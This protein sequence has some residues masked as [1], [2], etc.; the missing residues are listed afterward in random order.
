M[1]KD[2][3]SQ[4]AN[5]A[6]C[7]RAVEGIKSSCQEM[8]GWLDDADPG[9]IEIFSRQTSEALVCLNKINYWIEHLTRKALREVLRFEHNS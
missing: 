8:I 9:D 6:E 4:I 3:L 2:E 7:Q 1:K 5:L